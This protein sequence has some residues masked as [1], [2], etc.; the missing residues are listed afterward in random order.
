MPQLS[1][2]LHCRHAEEPSSLIS[3]VLRKLMSSCCSFGSKCV[4]PSHSKGQICAQPNYGEGRNCKCW[5][6]L[7]GKR[8]PYPSRS[9]GAQALSGALAAPLPCHLSACKMSNLPCG[10][11]GPFRTCGCFNRVPHICNRHLIAGLGSRKTT[12]A[13]AQCNRPCALCETTLISY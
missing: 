1:G 9:D 4:N 2:C 11:D 12:I 3:P 13:A 7:L 6:S 8:G 5:E 10:A